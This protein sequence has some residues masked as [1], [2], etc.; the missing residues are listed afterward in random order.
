MTQF[1]LNC[2]KFSERKIKGL[3]G[4][5]AVTGDSGKV[6]AKVPRCCGSALVSVYTVLELHMFKTHRTAHQ[7]L[8]FTSANLYKML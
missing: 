1:H 7:S 4:R 8:V 3:V 5:L 6:E 2:I